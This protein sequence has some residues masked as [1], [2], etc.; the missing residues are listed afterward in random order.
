[1]DLISIIMSV[2]LVILAVVVLANIISRFL[3]PWRVTF[4]LKTGRTLTLNVK[5]LYK[6]KIGTY[7]WE[8]RILSSSR[9]LNLETDDIE[10]IRVTSRL[11]NFVR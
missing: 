10:A 7:G 2:L 3:N 8:T 1:M 4:Y 11:A 9:L 5:K 6:T